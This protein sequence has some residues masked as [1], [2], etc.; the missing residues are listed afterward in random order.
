LKV[1][2]D[3]ADSDKHGDTRRDAGW[4]G[5]QPWITG[6]TRCLRLTGGSEPPSV[7]IS[8]SSGGPVASAVRGD[9]AAVVTG[10]VVGRDGTKIGDLQVLLLDGVT[11]FENLLKDWQSGNDSPA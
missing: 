9:I 2:V 11:M 7:E 1:L 8:F 5:L 6:L 3:L 10:D 4:S